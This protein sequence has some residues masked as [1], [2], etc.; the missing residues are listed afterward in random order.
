MH[1]FITFIYFYIIKKN[2][3]MW[4]LAVQTVKLAKTI[5]FRK[6]YLN[7]KVKTEEH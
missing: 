6:F 4:R 7:T 1:S 3:N 5:K 2:Q